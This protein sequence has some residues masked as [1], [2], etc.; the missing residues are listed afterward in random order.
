MRDRQFVLACVVDDVRRDLANG[1]VDP[2]AALAA[3]LEAT[4]EFVAAET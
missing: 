4:T 2:P 3:L 1:D